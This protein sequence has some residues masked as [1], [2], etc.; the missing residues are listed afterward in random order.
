MI[1]KFSP[2]VIS[3]LIVPFFSYCSSS[4]SKVSDAV[5]SAGSAVSAAISSITPPPSTLSVGGNHY[6]TGFY[7]INLYTNLY[8]ATASDLVE[9][10]GGKSYYRPP[11]P[12]LELLTYTTP[13]AAGAVGQPLYCLESQQNA[14]SQWYADST[15][16]KYLRSVGVDAANRTEN[17][18]AG[19]DTA[20]FDAL[21]AFCAA[22]C[23]EPFNGIQNNNVQTVDL[24]ASAGEG[25]KYVFYKQSTDNLL[26]SSKG[27]E[28][29]I[30]NGSLWFV[31]CY[32]DDRQ[33]NGANAR[34]QAVALPAGLEPYFL[35]LAQPSGGSL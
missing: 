32:D 6:V 35:Q 11:H 1:V 21:I 4:V 2:I 25:T 26:C 14:A 33:H 17:I 12:S 13:T 22:N 34:V 7:D 3:L 16:W 24:P 5:S 28:L 18:V 20:K 10:S 29:I 8:V 23:R 31:F 15:H 27:Y 9:Q 30:H 19:A